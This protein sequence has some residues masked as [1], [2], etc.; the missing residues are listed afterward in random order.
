MR[1]R[2][3]RLGTS[4]RSARKSERPGAARRSSLIDRRL[5]HRPR[6]R[7]RSAARR[8]AAARRRRAGA[9]G[10]PVRAAARAA[11]AAARCAPTGTARSSRGSAPTA[12]RSSSRR[13]VTRPRQLA[14]A[15]AAVE[16][17]VRAAVAHRV[18]VTESPRPASMSRIA[19]R[20]TWPRSPA[21]GSQ[22]WLTQSAQPSTSRQ[23][24]VVLLDLEHQAA[25]VRRRAP[26]C[27]LASST[28]P[29]NTTRSSPRAIASRGVDAAPALLAAF[30]APRAAATRSRSA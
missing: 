10:C 20:V 7:G 2:L 30:P 15:A 19:T 8:V 21:F 25:L 13:R 16:A 6:R 14:R 29:A 17:V 24:I 4:S 3:M 12:P 9:G 5:Q 18:V 22:Q 27:S 26:G 28:E 11:C 1:P 23:E